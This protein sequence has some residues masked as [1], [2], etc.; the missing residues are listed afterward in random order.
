MSIP[1]WL[2]IA[3]QKLQ[4]RVWTYGGCLL[5]VTGTFQSLEIR[6]SEM[7]SS[8]R[9]HASLKYICR[10][11]QEM[12]RTE[13]YIP[14]LSSLIILSPKAR[15]HMNFHGQSNQHKENLVSQ[16]ST[17]P[18]QITGC[19]L[20]GYLTVELPVNFLLQRFPPGHETLP[21]YHDKGSLY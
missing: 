21:E 5:N 9:A 12:H 20:H 10:V 18:I 17:K 7:N 14:S 15:S 11:P 1:C 19:E 4:T 16:N 6:P 3:T 13:S 8:F 2:W